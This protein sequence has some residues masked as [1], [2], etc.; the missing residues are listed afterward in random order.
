ME[1]K[2]LLVDFSQSLDKDQ[3]QSL[4][5]KHT[6][7]F[8]LDR[9]THCEEAKAKLNELRVA[10][11][12]LFAREYNPDMSS[13][14]RLAQSRL[15]PFVDF[16]MIVCSEPSL[17]F[18]TAVY[19]FGIDQFIA[20]KTWSEEASG[21]S[22]KIKAHLDDKNSTEFTTMQL[23][24]AMKSGNF[25]QIEAGNASLQKN[26]KR[27]YRL[28]FAMG[29]ASEVLGNSDEAVSWYRTAVEQNKLFCPANTSLAET[30][31]LTGGVDE[32]IA[33]FEM[34]DRS[35]PKEMERKANL[36]FA[37]I[38]KGDFASAEKYSGE[39]EATDRK[40]SRVAE[41]KA[42]VYLRKGNI[43]EAFK[44][45]DLMSDVGPL[46]AG[47]LNDLG[48][49]LSQAGKGRSALALYEKAHKIVR[50]E[51][52]YKISLNAALVSR[53]LQDFDL[54]LSY[55]DRCAAEYGSM[56]PNLG[57]IQ[58]AILKEKKAAA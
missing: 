54:A 10:Q 46:F 2:T 8:D 32:A 24:A 30:L 9:A 17:N 57:I 48:I 35:N 1:Y 7:A 25:A 42:Q 14:L 26:A 21:I 12:V 45:M 11:L 38:E 56:F 22:R 52:R 53:R 3:L 4:A 34:L 58:N 39:V 27:D 13:L 15:G 55:I 49:S 6:F 5:D 47:K 43:N 20:L 44:L 19:E 40:S 18:R 41:L 51:C 16:Q 29:K 23:F 31:L 36:A 28:A 33:I 37:F 50:P